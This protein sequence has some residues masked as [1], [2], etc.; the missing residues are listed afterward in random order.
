MEVK[1]T[2]GVNRE[3]PRETTKATWEG[4]EPRRGRLGS[5]RRRGRVGRRCG[6]SERSA[7]T[8]REAV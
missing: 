6:S 2:A 3:Q 8:G 7:R 1:R 4:A 5:N